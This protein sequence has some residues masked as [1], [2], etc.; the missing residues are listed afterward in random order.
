MHSQQVKVLLVIVNYHI[1]KKNSARDT[2]L[3]G[4]SVSEKEKKAT[5]PPYVIVNMLRGY[6][7]TIVHAESRKRYADKLQI[8]NGIGSY[9]LER[10]EWQ[11]NISN[12]A[13]LQVPVSDF[14][15]QPLNEG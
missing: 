6:S 5:T 12:Y 7:W 8:V 1:C 13:R 14:V 15:S 3:H 2:I 4:P 10:S 11:D 9:E